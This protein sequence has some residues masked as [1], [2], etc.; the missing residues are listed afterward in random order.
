MNI[1]ISGVGG[2]GV[3]LV[4][5]VLANAA[6][7]AGLEVIGADTF[8]LSH[9]GGAVIS[10]LRIAENAS[11][12]IPEG[13]ADVLLA[14]EPAEAL[15]C[16]EFLSKSTT[17]VTSTR[18]IIPSIV[19]IGKAKY[20]EVEEILALLRGSAKRV[21]AFDAFELA[22]KAGAAIATNFVV[23]GAA[24]AVEK[25]PVTKEQVEEAIRELVPKGTEEVNL[26]AFRSG[27]EAA[28]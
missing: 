19:F 17:I 20:P 1:I 6:I 26:R 24:F 13:K 27:M 23:L 10:H 16:A 2:Q 7:G 15:R 14:L 18:A 21:V 4:S 9:R 8:G 12:L 25:F 5:D 3:V 28:R 11:P 22:K